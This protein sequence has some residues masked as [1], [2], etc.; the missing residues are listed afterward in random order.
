MATN[1]G[2]EIESQISDPIPEGMIVEDGVVIQD[3]PVR[4]KP[5]VEMP[6]S[7]DRETNDIL[8]RARRPTGVA[9]VDADGQ[10]IGDGVGDDPKNNIFKSK[11][12]LEAFGAEDAAVFMNQRRGP[13]NIKVVT[14]ESRPADTGNPDLL[15]RGNRRTGNA[16]T[17]ETTQAP[18]PVKGNIPRGPGNF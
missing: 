18:R 15:N 4:A 17:V 3:A 2:N 12:F 10:F 7:A 14:I 11:D 5:K 13:K 16:P 8:R 9:R 1:N 6:E